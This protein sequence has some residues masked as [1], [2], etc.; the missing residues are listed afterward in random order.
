[1]TLDVLDSPEAVA[2]A[3]ARRFLD[4]AP[5]SVGLA[6]GST[7]ARLYRLL[8]HVDLGDVEW[9]FGDDRWV[10]ADH[11]Q[12]NEGMARRELLDPIG[13]TRVHPMF[14]GES[15]AEDAAAYECELGDTVL[16]LLLVGLGDDGHTLSVF[17]GF[18]DWP[19]APGRV[20]ATRAPANWPDR[21]TLLP[22]YAR[23]AREIHFLVTGEAKAEALERLLAPTGDERVTPARALRG[24]NVRIFCDADA[25]GR[26]TG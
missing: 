13:A 3:A 1:M 10:P 19:T 20:A 5:R 9:W 18:D 8:R 14:R 2:D 7:P 25:A 24:P 16:D 15:P 11:E 26:L 22:S 4:L 17:P 6:G 12:S 21:I 23:T